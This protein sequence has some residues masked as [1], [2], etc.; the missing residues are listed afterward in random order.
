[1]TWSSAGYEKP[2]NCISAIGRHPAIARPTQIPAIPASAIG[3]SNTRSRPNSACR[4]SVTRKTPPSAPTSSPNTSVRGSAASASRSAE[5]SAA[6]IVC[7]AI[8][9]ELL[10][11]AEQRRRRVGERVVEHLGH[12]WLAERGEL[13]A[14]L[15]HPGLRLLV[16]PADE[17]VVDRTGVQQVRSEAVDRVAFAPCRDLGLVAVAG[18]VVGGRVRADAVGDRLDQGGAL[19][20]SRAFDRLP[21]DGV[22]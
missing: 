3:V 8:A 11:L 5:F 15:G 17:G 13:G 20:R 22:H 7:S 4:P 18:C 10:T 19:A 1:M 14:D 21:R 16:A 6:T 2:S 12:R 9:E